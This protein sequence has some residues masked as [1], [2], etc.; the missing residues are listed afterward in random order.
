MWKLFDKTKILKSD[1]LSFKNEPLSGLSV[2]LL[3]VLDIFIFSNVM[4]GIEGETAKSPSHYVYY[5]SS[6]SNHFDAPKTSY[7]G[8]GDVVRYR[9]YTFEEQVSPHCEELRQKISRFSQTAH[10]KERLKSIRAIDDKLTQNNKRLRVISQQY[11]TRLFERIA[12]MPNNHALRSA[13]DEYEALNSDNKKLNEKKAAIPSVT[14]LDGYREYRD[15]V[16]SN[17]AAFK[18]AK[19]SYEFWQPFREFAHV[20]TFVLPLLLVFGFFYYRSKRKELRGEHYNP[21]VK[22]I[23]THISLILALPL[24]WYTIYIIYH[25]M[26]K[27]LLRQIID[28]L[29]SVGL[30]SILNYLAIAAVVLVFGVLIYFIQKRTIR[31][32]KIGSEKNIKKII[33][34][35]QCPRCTF[36]VD[37]SKPHCPFCGEKLLDACKSCGEMTIR[38]LPYCQQ[39][40]ESSTVNQN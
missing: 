22:I 3:I 27:T 1:L 32:K 31:H 15:Y 7:S 34:F 16:V 20:L 5:P 4:V 13:K 18:A 30:L 25:V 38:G 39:C 28:Y 24:I 12:L 8:F 23:S 33:S 17:K 35:S 29:V 36:K 14:T 11:N 9:K 6:C 10:F 40:G 21:I 19:E 37:Y 26:P 2:L